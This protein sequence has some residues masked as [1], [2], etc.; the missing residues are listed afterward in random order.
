MN[1]EKIGN[2][3]KQLRKEK[4]LTQEQLAEQFNVSRRTV[5]RWETGNNMPDLGLL[6]EM[7]D[8]YEVSLRELLDGERKSE[9]MNKE[10]EETVL[11]VADYSNDE[12]QRLLHRM[13]YLLIIG[14]IGFMISMIIEVMNFGHISPYQEISDFGLGLAF[15]TMIVQI[16]FTSKY[17]AKIRAFK[18]RLL[19]KMKKKEFN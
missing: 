11:K 10:L 8:Y 1:Q 3:L 19:K 18:M 16:I 17:E 13:H 4:N 15:G 2:F 6:I 9:K 7:S 5:S 14:F 12:K